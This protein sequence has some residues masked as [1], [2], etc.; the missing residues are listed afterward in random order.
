MRTRHTLVVAALIG[1][2]VAG[3]GIAPAQS[4]DDQPPV[5]VADAVTLLPGGSTLVD[6]MANDSDDLDQQ[7]LC[8][9]RGNS[10]VEATADHGRVFV[11]VPTDQ[12]GDYQV[13][14]QACDYD[15]LSVGTVTV[16][17][18]APQQLVVSKVVG[19]PGVLHAT[20]PNPVRVLVLW[21]KPHARHLGGHFRLGAGKAKD[22]TVDSHRI[23]WIALDPSSYWDDG[24]VVGYGRV[25]DID[26]PATRS[27]APRR[28]AARRWMSLWR[29]HTMHP[30]G[31][32]T[33]S[34]LTSAPWPTDPTTVQPPTPQTDTIHWWS[35]SWDRVHVLGNDTDPQGQSVD[36][37]RLSPEATTPSMR[38]V[39]TPSVLDG[40]LD[41]GT[42][43]HA[44]G[45]YEV[46]Y[47]VC[48]SGRLAPAVLRV[49]L[50]Q[51]KPV[52]VRRLANNPHL[53]RVHNPNPGGVRVTIG[54]GT[55]Q[56]VYVRVGP[57]GTRVVRTPLRDN[58]WDAVI[59][60]HY[61][62]AGSG[63]FAVS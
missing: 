35:G 44:S 49:V 33:G 53:V 23:L 13:Q 16:H 26:L 41:L 10:D 38:S 50:R 42:V 18:V 27:N 63:H 56:D 57:F 61:G 46:P 45:T 48:N 24:S 52:T 58:V 36:V 12:P 43:R 59:G 34:R 19:Q 60:H 2:M 37:C 9:A 30:A 55:L 32:T 8:R 54:R 28:P 5:A 25:K 14:Y 51:A 39:F 4:A 31:A 20:N 17:A 1:A 22:F 11:N 6:V 7:A 21:A 29:T 47:F 40:R 3:P 62:Y 15:Y